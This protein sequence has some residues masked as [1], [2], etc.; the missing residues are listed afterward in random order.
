[1]TSRDNTDSV[2][3]GMG[4]PM[5]SVESDFDACSLAAKIAARLVSKDDGEQTLDRYF[6]LRKNCDQ[7][8]WRRVLAVVASRSLSDTTFQ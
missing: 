6:A 5:Y 1:M 7:Q 2:I 8:L 4:G 3:C